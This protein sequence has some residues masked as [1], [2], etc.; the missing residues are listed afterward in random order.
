MNKKHDFNFLIKPT[1]M[2][3]LYCYFKRAKCKENPSKLTCFYSVIK[4][5]YIKIVENK[6]TDFAAKTI[7][8]QKNV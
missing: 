7:S 8:Y 2:D 1:Q 5:K 3:I 6:K 4:D